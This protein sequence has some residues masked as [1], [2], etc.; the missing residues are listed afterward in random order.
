[1]NVLVLT[2]VEEPPVTTPWGATSAC[3]LL[4]SS[5]NSSVGDAK[6]S[7]NVAL[8]KPPAAMGAPIQRVATCVAVH[9]AT[10]E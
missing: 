2:F 4:A 9:L 6:T 7:M 10:T 3:V 8:H 1:M 5:M